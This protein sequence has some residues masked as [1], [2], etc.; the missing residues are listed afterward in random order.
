[1]GRRHAA[2]GGGP[3]RTTADDGA[4]YFG[5]TLTRTY[6]RYRGSECFTAEAAEANKYEADQTNQHVADLFG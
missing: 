3:A 1:M 4:I 6:L 2:G 5:Q